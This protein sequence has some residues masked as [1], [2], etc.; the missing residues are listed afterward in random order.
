M[1]V[2]GLLVFLVGLV[3]CGGSRIHSDKALVSSIAVVTDEDTP[4]PIDASGART[5]GGK[6]TYSLTAP[7]DGGVDGT[8]PLFTYTPRQDFAG[9]D[10]FQISIS[11]GASTVTVPVTITVRPVNDAPV[12]VDDA[13]ATAVDTPL[14]IPKDALLANDH[15][16]DSPQLTIASVADVLGGHAQDAGSAVSFIPTA[17]FRG[18]ARFSYTLSDGAATAT[19]IVTVMVGG[20]A[21]GD[22]VV[23]AD[24]G[25]DAVGGVVT[26]ADLGMGAAVTCDAGANCDPANVDRS[27]VPS[28]LQVP[29]LAFDASQILLV[30]HKPESYAGVVDYNVYMD[31]HLLGGADANNSQFSPAKKYVNAFYA[32]DTAKFHV[33]ATVHSFTVDGL[34]PSSEH[35][36]TV[37]SLLADGSESADSSAIVQRT[38]TLPVVVDVGAAPYLAVGDGTTLNTVAIQAAI[39][40]CPKNGKVLIPAGV[41]KTGALFL[42]SNMT[43]ELGDGATLLG[44]ANADDYP[45]DKGYTLYDYLTDRRPPSL[46]NAIDQTRH[47]VGTFENIRIVGRG[48]IDG[49]GWLKTAAGSVVDELGTALPQYRASTSAKVGTDGVLARD[50]VAKAVASGVALD[51]AYGNRRSSLITLRGVRDVYYS[52]FLVLNPA[53]HG[54]MNLETANVVVNGVAFET[55]DANNG[56]GIEFGNSDGAL[57]LNSFFDTG[58]DCL[59]F[60][61]GLGAAA[62]TQ[63]PSQNAWIFDNYFREGHGAVVAGSHTGAWI[64]HVLAEDNVMLHTDIGLR[65]KSTVQAGG[66][67]RDFVFRDSAMKDATTN[68]FIF[69]L[70]YTQ[71]NNVYVSAPTPAEFRDILVQ[72][73]TVDGGGSTAIQVDGF[74]PATAVQDLE[75]YGDVYNENIVFKN[76]VMNGLRPTKIDHLRNSS[77]ENVVFRS[78]VGN[79]P[80]WVITNSP[81]LQFLGTTPA[82]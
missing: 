74:D 25:G 36:F 48:A 78:V 73:V 56:D 45:L 5:G 28:Q 17:S 68:G 12:A 38:G 62:A 20:D 47:S 4:I 54:I 51:M 10:M 60:A 39:D 11:D 81:G 19:A 76:V 58:D 30:W 22:T 24:A 75:G 3:G 42:K 31:G 2:R 55:Y 21:G 34:V 71:N 41:F 15:D 14:T 70:S 57:V 32:A 59:N 35:C 79:A 67:G 65:M 61:A 33:R 72:N 29:A 23:G 7:Q 13:F 40:A 63:P 37:R 6:L 77:F 18:A 64:Q 9:T 46:I 8:G 82:P 52:G 43:L 66:G 49:N 26:C 69:T 80:P 27:I 16:V 50:Q 1:Y 53:F 44:S